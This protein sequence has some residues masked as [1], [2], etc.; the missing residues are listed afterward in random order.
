MEWRHRVSH[1]R[2]I[3]ECKNWVENIS[4]WFFEIKTASSWLIIIQRAKLSTRSITPLCWC[5]WRTLW[6][7]TATGN[8]PRWTCSWTT[9]P[10]LTGHLQSGRNWPTLSSNVLI[11]HP[12]LR[13][14]RRRTT[15][16]SLDWK[17]NW[18]V[19]IFH[20]TRKSLLPR[21]PGWTDNFL[22]F[23][24]AKHEATR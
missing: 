18:S 2:K 19:N 6:R 24:S 20:P 22:C 13:I 9:N 10:R 5:N 11:S 14:W 1:R 8:S 4:P 21:R 15:T 17:S 7:K 12:V 23:F 3:S 16:C